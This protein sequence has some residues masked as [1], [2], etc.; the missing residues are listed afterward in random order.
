[1]FYNLTAIKI[2]FCVFKK[3]IKI[4]LPL[5]PDANVSCNMCLLAIVSLRC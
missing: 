1:M 2:V 4:N 3:K 5:K